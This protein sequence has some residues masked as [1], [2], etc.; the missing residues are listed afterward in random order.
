M[1]TLTKEVKI[2]L[3]TKVDNRESVDTYLGE[4]K[5]WLRK[6][7]VDIQVN[8]YNPNDPNSPYCMKYLRGI[9]NSLSVNQ[10]ALVCNSLGEG[11]INLDVKD[12]YKVEVGIN[13]IFNDIDNFIVRVARVTG[14]KG[15]VW[16]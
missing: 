6:N 10:V 3:G 16:E 5:A 7:S 12:T 14:F 15:E 4:K 9:W 13:S 11:I 8:D 1:K 2:H